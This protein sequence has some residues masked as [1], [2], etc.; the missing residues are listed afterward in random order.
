MYTVADL[1]TRQLVTLAEDDDLTQAER[2]LARGR[3]RHLPVTRDRRLVGLITHRDLLRAAHQPTPVPAH[4]VMT[5]E[6]V[7]VT[8]DTPLA[9]A[10]RRLLEGK[11][12]CVPVVDGDELVGLLTEAVLVRFALGLVEELDQGLGG[13]ETVRASLDPPTD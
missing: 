9:A 7:T 6:L 2:L 11:L 8:S 4:Q 3:I 12:G 13:L 10:A 1:M 5:R